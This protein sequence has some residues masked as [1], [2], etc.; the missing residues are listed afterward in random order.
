MALT[1][2]DRGSVWTTTAGN[3]AAT[4]FT[5]AVGDIIVL[6]CANSGRTTAQPP[7]VTDNNS[8]GTYTQV[9]TA[10]TK[11]TSADSG[12]FFIR[13]TPIASASS[14]TVTMTQSGDSGG[15]YQVWTVGPMNAGGSTLVGA[16]GVQN[17]QSAG[18]PSITLDATPLSTSA[19]LG[20]VVTGTNGSANS[21]P[22]TNFAE[23][24][25]QGYNTP[26]NGLEAVSRASGHTS[27]TVAWTAATP[28]SFGSSAIEIKAAQTVTLSLITQ[29]ASPTAPTITKQNTISPALLDNTAVITAPTITTTYTITTALIDQTA[30]P[31]APSVI[32][33]QNV[34]L[35]LIDRTASPTAPTITTTYTTTLP[36]IDQTASPTAPTITTE[37]VIAPALLNQTAV[38]TAPTITTEN[39]IA[40]A[41]LD[42]T[43]TATAPTI[44]T[45]NVIALTLI[46]QTAQ[47]FAPEVADAG[48]G[49][50]TIELPLIDRTA[51]PTAPT[52]TTTNTISLPLI[53]QTAVITA[54]SV[55]N[56]NQ[57]VLLPFLDQTAVAFAPSIQGG[58]DAGG[59]PH[60]KFRELA[61]VTS[62]RTITYSRVG[63][64]MI[65]NRAEAIAPSVD[66]N[67]DD[68]VLEL[69]LT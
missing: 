17:N 7:T 32:I 41:L 6:F 50:E 38:A 28:S 11:N 34:E 4:A 29:T 26:P 13:D 64:S 48:G 68:L 10:M 45:E 14:T 15:G 21:A 54:P 33:N 46:D 25:D 65:D 62:F 12:W 51:S 37:N 43:A 3:K 27:T 18:T 16:K 61:P 35:P 24:A 1:V 44:T 5:P 42:Q 53:D 52:I 69:L 60:G 9:G 47:P 56:L 20:A 36:L 40:P 66:V 23:D 55:A 49:A 30:S 63:L 19:I 57:D 22:P 8:S 58:A 59:R 31:T 2:T 39:I 67:D